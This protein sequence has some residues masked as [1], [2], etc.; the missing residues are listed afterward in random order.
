LIRQTFVELY[1]TDPLNSLMKDIDG[2]L[3]NVLLGTLDINLILDSEYC[4][5]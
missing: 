4:F 3:S 1:S 5:C 2:D